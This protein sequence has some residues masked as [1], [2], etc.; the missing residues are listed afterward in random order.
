MN[1]EDTFEDDRVFIAGKDC[2]KCNKLSHCHNND[3]ICRKRYNDLKRWLQSAKEWFADID[4]S[5]THLIHE[6]QL[7]KAKLF[8]LIDT[9]S[10]IQ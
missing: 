6:N 3:L 2:T 4:K 10:E 5:N 9:I 7:L 8:E 1:R